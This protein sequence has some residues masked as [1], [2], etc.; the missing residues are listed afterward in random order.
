MVTSSAPHVRIEALD[1][2]RGLVIVLMALDHV[3][4]YFGP[5]PF[6]PVDPAHTEPLWYFTRWV[7]HVC[8]PSFVFLAGVS[9][10]LYGQELGDRRRLTRFL[11]SR[12][13]WLCFLEATLVSFAWTFSFRV[14]ILQVI[15]ALGASMLVLAA[16]ARLPRGALIGISLIVIA[17]HNLLDGLT[18][19]AWGPL[20]ALW[21]A[22]H[23][24]GVLRIGGEAGFPI[25]LEYPLLPWIGVMTLG[26]ALGPVLS[27]R[28]E[29][30]PFL[31]RAG[32][33]LL[34][35]FLALR[36][37]NLYGDPIPWF[38]QARGTVFTVLSFLNVTKY[39]PS[40][41]YLAVTLGLS[42]W[43]LALCEHRAH[44]LSFLK[45]LGRVP[46]FFYLIH[47]P[48]IHALA[49]LG[50]WWL[51]GQVPDAISVAR[52]QFPAGY[53][54]SLAVVYLVWLALLPPLY[55]VCRRYDRIK[56]ARGGWLKYL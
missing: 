52:K 56:Q 49:L 32:A 35:L 50:A 2:L 14:V 29:R 45:V 51:F 7:T 48:L 11:W 43:L 55:L 31:W 34:A 8:A 25:Y 47:I 12:G 21:Q 22:L 10:Y 17:G 54:P 13:L 3:R 38:E 36:Y 24:P 46:L 4:G 9:A 1:A 44:R 6:S 5:T 20:A 42:A 27:D 40:L 19:D 33:V 30:Q 26:Y 15:W 37:P 16:V 39:P 23:E 28:A 53:E 18:P 41:A